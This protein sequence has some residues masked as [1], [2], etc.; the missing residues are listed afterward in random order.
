MPVKPS[1]EFLANGLDRHVDMAKS[2]NG[3]WMNVAGMGFDAMV[4]RRINRGF[5][6][7][8]GQIAYLL[9]IVSALREYQPISV[10]MNVDGESIERRVML[11]AVA[12]AQSYGGGLKIAP[13]AQLDDGELNLVI[14]GDIS[15][16]EFL[17]QF[18]RVYR[19]GHLG[20]P[21]VESWPC[22]TVSITGPA[23]ADVL[24][25]GEL[26]PAGRLSATTVPGAVRLRVPK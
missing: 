9:A 16:A 10:S 5:R 14:V 22:R 11:C 20:H 19:G 13:Q 4:A 12:N 1:F 8:K 3:F 23:S 25:D 26:G 6:F 2:T 17:K 21:A 7:A 15:K 18:P 24:Y